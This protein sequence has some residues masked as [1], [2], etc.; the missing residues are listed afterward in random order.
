MSQQLAKRIVEVPERYERGNESTATLVRETGY[1]D[2]PEPLNVTD[3]E[4]ALQQEPRLAD[5]WFGRGSDQRLVGGWGIER[6]DD[7]QYRVQSYSDGQWLKDR[8]R[9]RACAEFIIRYVGFIADTLR[10]N[11]RRS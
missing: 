3:V 4:R 9:Y 1:L 8:N 5:Q 6:D 7:G 2:A 11:S 10:N